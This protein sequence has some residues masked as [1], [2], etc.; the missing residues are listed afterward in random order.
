MKKLKVFLC[1]FIA[2]ILLSGCV[3]AD[4]HV[5]INKDGSGE[6]EYKI[7]TNSLVIEQLEPLKS[8]L[9][10]KGYQI[11]AIEQENQVGWTAK[12]EVPN[13][14]KEPP[15]QDLMEELTALDPS[16]MHVSASPLTSG[17]PVTLIQGFQSDA[18]TIDPGLFTILFRFDTEV[19]LTGMKNTGE[20]MG[21]MYGDILLQQMNLN[22]ILTLPIKPDK[23]NATSVSD[24]GN[25][26]TWK[27]TPGEV[28]PIL[29]EAEFPNP[30]TWGAIA[31]L[32]FFILLTVLIVWFV[33]RRRKARLA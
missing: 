30:L 28:N 12:K 24:D 25:T 23:H 6:Y 3:N 11:K 9:E 13:I 18:L 7:L 15:G 22:L 19:D 21:G 10:E 5:T 4:L 27:L 1:T 26:L 14:I 2:V 29:V 20:K 16:Q 17:P 31:L 33:R 8:T 32:L